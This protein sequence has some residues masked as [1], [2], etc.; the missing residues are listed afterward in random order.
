MKDSMLFSWWVINATIIIFLVS[1]A[2]MVFVPATSV[3]SVTTTFAIVQAATFAAATTTSS[4]TDYHPDDRATA[5]T[6]A[7]DN[8]LTTTM[9]SGDGSDISHLVFHPNI[10]DFNELS[11]GDADNDVVIVFNNHQNRSVY[12]G[13][14]SGNVPDFYSSF[15]EEK[16]IPPL[17]NTTFNVVFLPRQQGVIQ[18][19]L[20][21]HTSFGVINYTVRGKG[22][23]CLFRL[24]P[25]VGL[26]APFNATLTPEIYMYN[27]FSSPLQ[28]MEVYSSG[29][30]FHLELPSGGPEAPQALWEIPPYGSKPIIRVRFTST[31]PG[32]HTAYIR[33]K[34]SS[35]N[36]SELENVVLVVPIEVE[37]TNQYG[38]YSR[39]P[40]I[41]FGLGGNRDV[42]KKIVFRLFNSGPINVNIQ[43]V[44]IEGDAD[45]IAAISVIESTA[46]IN[47]QKRI[48]AVAD[49]SKIKAARYFKGNII[50]TSIVSNKDYQYK[51]PFH[52]ELLTGSI[53]YND[54]N[55]K[56]V[57]K[58]ATSTKVIHSTT[59]DF[60]LRNK[61]EVSLA[62]TNVTL[63]GDTAQFFKVSDFVPHILQPDEESFLFRLTQL[64][65]AT[66]RITTR[67]FLLHT[68]VSVYE[69]PVISFS[70][71]L[72]RIV[73][74]EKHIIGGVGP[75]EKS[76][77][78]G[79]LPLSTLT[80]TVLAF[81]NENPLPISI[82]NWKGTMSGVAS[83][84][85]ILRGCGNL[86]MDH[87]KFCYSIQPG[88]WIVF[89]ISVLSN[90]VGSFVGNF[91][92]KTDY[93]E[94]S[95]PVRFTTAIGR[96]EFK[97]I[98]F[99]HMECFPVSS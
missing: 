79:T 20:L 86:T 74:V 65:A 55:T 16:V 15:F 23:E 12:L 58:Q 67:N 62:I 4:T 34:I 47:E 57:A 9:D 59:K 33:I 35:A 30:Q 95:T 36:D 14:I 5:A 11:I 84:V 37:I 89:Q 49:W 92:V 2:F 77:N 81:V 26:K 73:P 93:E 63:P 82:H 40:I 50:V 29:G 18:S 75:D 51:I 13:S 90:A 98:M 8:R 38:I 53:S 22:V 48:T 41:N 44:S 64:G 69:I 87:L 61:Y 42:P 99:D 97:A 17:G 72:R 96:L 52:G 56:F 6:F 70:G 7:V 3:A 31:V 94:I 66:K 10:L 43:A 80:D 83:I 24:N 60:T 21:I 54:S 1:D 71:L 78:Y 45:V 88:E 19:H 39:I 68:N 28:I 85:I 27:P 32:N 25:L 76:I 91:F 46:D